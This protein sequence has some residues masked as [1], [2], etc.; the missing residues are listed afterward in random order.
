MTS[1]EQGL[2][3][4]LN[5]D[6][7][8]RLFEQHHLENAELRSLA[9]IRT[10]RM[11]WRQGWRSPSREQSLRKTSPTL[12]KSSWRNTTPTLG[13][14]PL[15]TVIC[16]RGQIKECF[17]GTLYR[18]V[19]QAN[20]FLMTGMSGDTLR[21][22]SSADLMKEVALSSYSSALLRLRTLE[23]STAKRTESSERVTHRPEGSVLVRPH[24]PEVDFSAPSTRSSLNWKKP[25]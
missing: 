20:L 22:K 2:Y 3:V 6:S 12:S 23:R 10:R 25:L 19:N 11:K 9:K 17:S 1:R 14:K 21:K 4:T 5:F 13:S 24:L 15:V 7:C 8:T 18:V 16:Q